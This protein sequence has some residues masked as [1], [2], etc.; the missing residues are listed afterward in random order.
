MKQ[1]L[2]ETFDAMRQAL[3]KQDWESLY[4]YAEPVMKGVLIGALVKQHIEV[5]P[6]YSL[7]TIHTLCIMHNIDVFS[8]N[9]IYAIENKDYGMHDDVLNAV[10]YIC[11]LS[12]LSSIKETCG[13]KR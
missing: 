13:G 6:E 9:S 3:D 10:R 12:V 8:N 5:R 7:G 2:T 4:T 1:S 11:G